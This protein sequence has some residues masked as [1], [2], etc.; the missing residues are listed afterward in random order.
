LDVA[1]DCVSL[2]P[3]FGKYVSVE[4]S[5]D[6]KRQFI[7]PRGLLTGFPGIE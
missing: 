1:V 7:I 4:L 6:N 5:E 2:L 3:T